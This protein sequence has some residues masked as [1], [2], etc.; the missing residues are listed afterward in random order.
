MNNEFLMMIKQLIPDRYEEFLESLKKPFHKG[1]RIN[2]L[3]I[4]DEDF[5]NFLIYKKA[6]QYTL[7]MPIYY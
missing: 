6:H 2:S 5:F 7:K 3:K 4:S 1:F